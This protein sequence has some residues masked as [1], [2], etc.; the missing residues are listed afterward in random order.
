M[1]EVSGA[2][3]WRSPFVSLCSPRQ[4]TEY[5]VMDLQYVS[6]KEKPVIRGPVSQKVPELIF[7]R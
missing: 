4:L 3:F 5:M 2:N 1:A 7:I 6:D